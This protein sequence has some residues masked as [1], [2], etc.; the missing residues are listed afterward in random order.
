MARRRIHTMLLVLMVGCDGGQQS[1]DMSGGGITYDGPPTAQAT[2]NDA[3]RADPT[4]EQMIWRLDAFK[5]SDGTLAE[6]GTF[7]V[8]LAV[9]EETTLRL[10]SKV[11]LDCT[12]G[13]ASVDW[14]STRTRSALVGPLSTSTGMLAAVAPGDTSVYADLTFKNGSSARAYPAVAMADGQHRVATVRVLEAR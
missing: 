1:C 2:C 11:S 5:E 3:W 8:R 10:A 12:S 4:G 14:Q 7:L 6:D 9:G 13:F